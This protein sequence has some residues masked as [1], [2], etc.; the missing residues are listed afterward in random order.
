MQ[1]RA[2]E[3]IY[4][5]YSC[6]FSGIMNFLHTVNWETVL[7]LL[8]PFIIFGIGWLFQILNNRFQERQRLFDRAKFLKSS[9]QALKKPLEN[10][11]NHHNSLADKIDKHEITQLV[12][13]TDNGLN[14]RF[15]SD[16]L[17]HDIHKLL[18]LTTTNGQLAVHVLAGII[19]KIDNIE[20][21]L[22]FSIQNFIEYLKQERENIQI[23][24]EPVSDELY[25]QNMDIFQKYKHKDDWK[26]LYT[27][28]LQFAYN[29]IKTSPELLK[30]E[31]G[32][33]VVH[34]AKITSEGMGASIYKNI[35]S[36]EQ[37]LERIKDRQDMTSGYLRKTSEILNTYINACEHFTVIL[38]LCIENTPNYRRNPPTNKIIEDKIEAL[39]KLIY[40]NPAGEATQQ[41]QLQNTDHQN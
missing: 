27:Q 11:I 5:D 28:Y 33:M 22:L 30:S 21:G 25:E 37:V 31:V 34:S 32:A 18:S 24:L 19:N 3:G 10:Q 12:L 14:T 9:L 17:L 35:F 8:T 20:K 1:A 39:H 15:F 6:I 38:D 2:D 36:I 23:L 16:M 26:K 7:L 29:G 40:N 13:R 41:N 4:C